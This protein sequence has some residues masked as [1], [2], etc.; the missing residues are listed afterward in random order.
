MDFENIWGKYQDRRVDKMKRIKASRTIIVTVMAFLVLSVGGFAISETRIKDNVDYP[1]ILDQ[2]LVGGWNAIDFVSEK[3]DFDPDV[4]TTSGELYLKELYFTSDGLVIGQF[5]EDLYA[6]TS[7]T[8]T[9]DH[10]LNKVDSTDSEYEIKTVGGTTYLFMQWK[11][12][13][14]V[15]NRFKPSYYV[16]ERISDIDMIGFE[17][18]NVRNDDVNYVFE[19]DPN[20]LGNWTSIDFV[21]E[22]EE[23]DPSSKFWMGDLFLDQIEVKDDGTVLF[24]QMNSGMFHEG[25]KWT[26]G[27]LI[28]EDYNCVEDYFIIE[29]NGKNYLMLPW[30]NGDVIYRGMKPCYYVFE[31]TEE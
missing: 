9:K 17:N 12:G 14:Y 31:R 2:D 22:I 23:F 21:S 28:D 11:S 13:D 25:G 1:F 18:Q 15:F 3:E 19:N 5:D 29:V 8:Y 7:F 27:K 6:T 30:I 10:I 20:I 24:K 16:F 4:I 26:K